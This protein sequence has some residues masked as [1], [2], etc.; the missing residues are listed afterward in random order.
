MFV[1]IP[2]I[3]GLQNAFVWGIVL[4]KVFQSNNFCE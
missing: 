2:S 1:M 4:A 3:D